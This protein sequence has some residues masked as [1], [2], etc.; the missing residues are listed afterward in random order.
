MNWIY[1]NYLNFSQT[2]FDNRFEK[3]KIEKFVFHYFF[4]KLQKKNIE[5]GKKY[6]KFAQ[7]LFINFRI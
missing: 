2:I 5:N 3:T 1:F 6:N 4:K 7:F